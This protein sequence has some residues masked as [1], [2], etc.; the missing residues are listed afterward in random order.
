MNVTEYHQATDKVMLAI[1][2]QHTV[3]CRAGCW[4][5]CY[6]A[7]YADE[8][9]VD[10]MLENFGPDELERIRS[11]TKVWVE[12]TKPLIGSL[13]PDAVMWRKLMAPCPACLPVKGSLWSV[14]SAYNPTVVWRLKA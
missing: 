9:E 4:W 13:L 5:C 14:S 8:R 11:L 6:E 2:R 1:E 3:T 10:H 12:R 7:A